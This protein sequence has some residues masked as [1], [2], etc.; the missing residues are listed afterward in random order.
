MVMWGGARAVL[1][2]ILGVLDASFKAMLRQNRF[3]NMTKIKNDEII[4]ESKKVSST[5]FTWLGCVLG[6]SG[7]GDDPRRPA[8][9]GGGARFSK[10]TRRKN[11]RF[12]HENVYNIKIFLG[13]YTT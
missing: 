9:G 11:H 3:L 5:W 7:T 2:T 6:A 12:F 10:K 13:F 4:R 8:V 1:A